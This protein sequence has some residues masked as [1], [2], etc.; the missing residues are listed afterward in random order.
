M[1]GEDDP[2]VFVYG[3]GGPEGL[4]GEERFQVSGEVK[5]PDTIQRITRR[6]RKEVVHENPLRVSGV[7]HKS[8]PRNSRLCHRTLDSVGVLDLPPPVTRCPGLCVS[9]VRVWNGASSPVVQVAL[10]VYLTR[11]AW[12]YRV[13][14][15]DY[16]SG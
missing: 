11:L 9:Y 5:G 2:G 13:G 8:Q 16:A 6:I 14:Y 1:G 15:D 3:G 10:F 12:L 4:G 7:P